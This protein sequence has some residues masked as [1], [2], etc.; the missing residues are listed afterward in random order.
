MKNFTFKR[1]WME[2][3]AALPNDFRARIVLAANDYAYFD[4]LP[5]DPI[6]AYA[7]RH[8]IAYIDRRKAAKKR[9]EKRDICQSRHEASVQQT[10][11]KDK[12]IKEKAITEP[13]AIIDSTTDVL[14]VAIENTENT[15]ST[16]SIANTEKPENA[17]STENFVLPMPV[18]K[19]HA[20]QHHTHAEKQTKS[21][22]DR[23]KAKNKTLTFRDLKHMKRST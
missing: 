19:S 3:M 22:T 13:Q 4:N 5:D 7:M 20:P 9:T 8:I 15:E 17:K 10:I 11:A 6:V 1:E 23:G 18:Y 12:S 16:A 14:A 21:H 2:E